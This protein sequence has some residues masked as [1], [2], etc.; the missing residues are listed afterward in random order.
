MKLH[1]Y[2]DPGHAWCKV[3][4]A[5]LADLGVLDK[6]SSYSYVRGSA[7]YLEEDCD[8]SLLIAAL[9]ARGIEPEFVE[10]YSDGDSPIRGYA[11][12]NS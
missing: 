11:R 8:A 6:V 12:F 3:D 5:L 10:H 2:N 9:R 4:R 1:F 7:V